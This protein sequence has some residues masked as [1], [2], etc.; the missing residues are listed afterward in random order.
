[1]HPQVYQQ[2]VGE[3]SVVSLHKGVRIPCRHADARPLLPRD[4]IMSYLIQEALA[5][6]TMLPTKVTSD[7]AT[8]KRSLHP[9]SSSVRQ[10]DKLREEAVVHC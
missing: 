6:V 1:M 10:R 2:L 3:M 5:A 9:F 8:A 4:I 7:L